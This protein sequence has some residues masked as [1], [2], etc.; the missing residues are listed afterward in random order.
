MK[1]ILMR[2]AEAEES[3]LLRYKDDAL[4]PLTRNGVET[5]RILA[6]G[7]KR[8]GLAPDRIVTSPK[9][10][11]RQTAEITAKALGLEDVLTE[12]P[13]LGEA[14]SLKAALI[15]LAECQVHETL[16]WVGHEPDLSELAS[17]LL[18]RQGF[19]LK[20]VKSGVLGI[21]FSGGARLGMGSLIYFYRPQDVLA[22]L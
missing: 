5:Q 18:A 1:L 10:R 22:L 13:G 15:L 16:L 19:N 3:D 7:L 2:H 11:A 4:R 17:A 20:F 6:R 12:N 9:L 8:M 21:K 14:Y